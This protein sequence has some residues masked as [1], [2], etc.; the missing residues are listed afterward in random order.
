MCLIALAQNVSPEFPLVIAANRDEEYARPSLRAHRWTDAPQV[1]GGRDVT[2]GGSWLAVSCEGRFAAVTNL[3]GA[4]TTGRSRGLL[5]TDYVLGRGEPADAVYAGFNLITGTIGGSARLASNASHA[6]LEFREGVHG[7]SN[8]GPGIEWPKVTRAV[9]HVR[10]VL[11]SLTSRDAI[12]DEL[13]RFL[14]TPGD[15]DRETDIFVKGDRYGTRSSTVVIAT[16]EEVLLAER[17]YGQG[18]VPDE[19]VELTG[20]INP[21]TLP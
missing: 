17:T 1:L 5:V 9:E 7:V 21:L 2:H 14:A 8:A 13:M 15:G 20:E 11:E 10:H 18:G 4:M 6:V 3:R 19:M 16:R 12:V